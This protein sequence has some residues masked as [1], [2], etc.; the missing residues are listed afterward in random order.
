MTADRAQMALLYWC[1][2]SIVLRRE[3]SNAVMRGIWQYALAFAWS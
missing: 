1:N 3:I 2:S